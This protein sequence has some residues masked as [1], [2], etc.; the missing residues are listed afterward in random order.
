MFNLYSVTK[1]RA[2][3]RELA[4]VTVDILGKLPPLPEIFPDQKAP[5]VVTRP[6][7]G[8]RELLMM[9]WGLPPPPGPGAGAIRNFFNTN[10]AWLQPYLRPYYRC[11]IPVT[12]FCK[13]EHM[14]GK[15]VPTWFALDDTRPLFFFAGI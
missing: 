9:R 14:D 3:I 11:L 7:D 6:Y 2:T 12:S 15:S 8:Q 1:P 5:V 13:C 4:E 10:E